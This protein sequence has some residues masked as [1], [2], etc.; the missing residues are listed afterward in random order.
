MKMQP[1][2]VCCYRCSVVVCLYIS[3]CAGH[4]VSP[5]KLAELIKMGRVEC[6]LGWFK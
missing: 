1:V 5:E 4:D 6:R 2:S 3:L